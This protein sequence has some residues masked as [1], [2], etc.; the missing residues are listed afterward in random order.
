MAIP[1][2]EIFT[3]GLRRLVELDNAWVPSGNGSSLYIRPFVYA[4][5]AKFGV[6]VSDQYRFLIFAGPVPALY[7]KPIKVKVETEFGAVDVKIARHHGK[8][9][10]AK[11]EYEQIREIALKSNRTLKEIEKEVLEK[12]N[13]NQGI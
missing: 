13:E 10:N 9:V 2:E 12:F 3:E 4:S 5:E 11:P 8:I 1:P 6:K 7:A